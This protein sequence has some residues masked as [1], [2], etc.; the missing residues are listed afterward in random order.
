MSSFLQS[1][2]RTG[3]HSRQP[4]AHTR[5]LYFTLFLVNFLI[6]KLY[7]YRSSS[8]GSTQYGIYTTILGLVVGYVSAK[9]GKESKY[10]R[11]NLKN[12]TDSLDIDV[13]FISTSR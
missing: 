4:T 12:F 8:V 5:A 10:G 6:K 11:C 13:S 9:T 3:T 2:T 7:R 1:S